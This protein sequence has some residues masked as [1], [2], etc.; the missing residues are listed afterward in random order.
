MPVPLPQL[1]TYLCRFRRI[2]RF[3]TYGHPIWNGLPRMELLEAETGADP[4]LSGSVQAFWNRHSL[5]FR[6]ICQDEEAA[7][8]MIHRDD[9]IYEE[10]V[11]EVFICDTS[12]LTHYKEF[13]LSPVNVKFDALIT[14]NLQGDV[15][16]DTDWDASNWKTEVTWEPQ[17][18]L[19][20]YV[21]EIPFVNFVGGAP[22]SGDEWRMNC[23]RIDRGRE[24][25]DEYTAWSPTGVINYHTPKRF[26]RIRFEVSPS[27]G[28]SGP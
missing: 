2:D 19:R 18:S 5:Y 8:T 9:P 11:V 21:W 4:C 23:Y 25:P 7:A 20:I 10:D 22:S 1:P 27:E 24:Q 28:E 15:R 14:N 16:V 12:D 6:F 13:Q 17:E 3:P 26:G